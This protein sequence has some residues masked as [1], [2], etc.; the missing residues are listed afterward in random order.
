MFMHADSVLEVD[1]VSKLYSRSPLESQHRMAEIINAAFWGRRFSVRGLQ[2]REFWALDDVS[3]SLRRGEAMGV[4]GLNGA[5]KTT[6]LRL[7]V[8]QFPP[9]A[10]EIR[11]AGKTAGMID[12]TAGFNNRM[13]GKEN[14]YLRSATLGRTREEVDALYDEIADFTELGEALS[15]PL[16]T[17]SAGMRMRLAF[18]TTIFVDPTLLVIDEVLAVGDFQFRQK[19]LERIRALRAKSAFVFASHSMTDVARFCNEAIVLEKGRIAFK[20]DPEEAIRCFQG[21][22]TDRAARREKAAPTA[23]KLGHQYHDD[24]D[25]TDVEAMWT[26]AAGRRTN[27]FA[28]G[29]TA[30]LRIEFTLRKPVD[31]LNIGVPIWRVGEE[32]LLSALSTE[33]KTFAIAPDAAGRCRVEVSVDTAVLPSGDYESVLAIVDGPKYLY[34]RPL[35]T[36]AIEPAAAPRNWGRFMVPHAWSNRS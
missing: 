2:K 11:I 8:G 26:N 3:F 29:E 32:D 6:L 21:S 36:F 7:L 4:I 25:I 24:G 15:A 10:G 16:S 34:R 23:D 18:A 33:Q 28:W 31:R 13:D 5:G 27:A 22:K 1:R 19:C 20:G 9:D 35:E 30:L 12:L 14:I 17:Y